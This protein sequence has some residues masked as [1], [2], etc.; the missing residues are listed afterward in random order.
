MYEFV[1][2]LKEIEAKSAKQLDKKDKLS[3][4]LS[5]ERTVIS[6]LELY[7]RIN[8]LIDLLSQA[9]DVDIRNSYIQ[10]LQ[11]I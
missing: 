5:S 8:K 1:L 6:T 2:Q 9:Y 11:P 4:N 7:K 10:L 3:L